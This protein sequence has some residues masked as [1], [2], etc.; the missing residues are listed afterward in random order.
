M[1]SWNILSCM[2][3]AGIRVSDHFADVGKMIK[4]GK[5]GHNEKGTHY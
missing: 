2:E 3:K 1:K 4:I 5:G